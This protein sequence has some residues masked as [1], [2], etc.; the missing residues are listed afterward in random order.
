MNRVLFLKT[1]IERTDNNNFYSKAVSVGKKAA[2]NGIKRNQI[3]NLENIANT[4]FKVSDIIDYVKKQTA[5]H[6]EWQR[7]I[8]DELLKFINED[9]VTVSKEIKKEIEGDSG[10]GVVPLRKIQL[11]LLRELIH[12]FAINYEYART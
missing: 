12:S 3:T 2:E 10:E 11:Q 7:G 6:R 8:G 9:V 5:R 1:I 4:T